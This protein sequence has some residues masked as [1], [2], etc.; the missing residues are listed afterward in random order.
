M[1]EYTFNLTDSNTVTIIK[2]DKNT[3]I[4]WIFKN[5]SK[6]EQDLKKDGFIVLTKID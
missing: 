6:L 5:L 2:A 4:E 3:P 1:F